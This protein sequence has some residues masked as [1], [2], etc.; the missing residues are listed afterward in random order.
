MADFGGRSFNM[1]MQG[2]ADLL[3]HRRHH[4]KE[5]LIGTARP[6]PGYGKKRENGYDDAQR[7]R[8]VG[9]MLC[10]FATHLETARKEGRS[11]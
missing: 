11:E 8:L 10:S 3:S 1:F 9:M 5:E 7:H 4:G 2:S 6:R